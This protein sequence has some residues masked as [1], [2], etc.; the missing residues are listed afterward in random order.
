MNFMPVG[1]LLKRDMEWLEFKHKVA[2]LF[3]QGVK[4]WSSM[5]PRQKMSEGKLSGKGDNCGGGPRAADKLYDQP[6][7]CTNMRE[8]TRPV[9]MENSRDFSCLSKEPEF[10]I[11]VQKS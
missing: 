11:Q 4:E 3:A 5:M 6:L 10:E 9:R 1:L 8:C 7:N 2:A